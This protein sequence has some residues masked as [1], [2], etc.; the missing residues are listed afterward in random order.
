MDP[1]GELQRSAGLWP[2]TTSSFEVHGATV[3]ALIFR[4]NCCEPDRL[5]AYLQFLAE[6]KTTEEVVQN[7]RSWKHSGLSVDQSVRLEA[8]DPEGVQRLIQ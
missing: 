8:G 1:Q 2:G 5:A 6:G 7:R 4:G 3:S